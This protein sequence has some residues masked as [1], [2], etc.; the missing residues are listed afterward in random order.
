M[1]TTP[2]WTMSTT[3]DYAAHDADFT[4]MFRK[5]QSGVVVYPIMLVD[6]DTMQYKL[7]LTPDGAVQTF[8]PMNGLGSLWT[9]LKSV[10]H[11]L[12]WLGSLRQL[13]PIEGMDSVMARVSAKLQFFS[14]I[15]KDYDDWRTWLAKLPSTTMVGANY[16]DSVPL[17]FVTHDGDATIAAVQRIAATTT[18]AMDEWAGAGSVTNDDIARLAAVVSDDSSLLLYIINGIIMSCIYRQILNWKTQMTAEE[19]AGLNVV[20]FRGPVSVSGNNTNCR[21]RCPSTNAATRIFK[22]FMTEEQ[23]TQRLF[24]LVSR[25]ARTFE[26]A[27]PV[28]EAGVHSRNIADMMGNG[29]YVD[30]IKPALQNVSSGLTTFATDDSTATVIQ[31]CANAVDTPACP[32]SSGR[33]HNVDG[34]A[35]T[36][37]PYNSH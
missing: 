8:M 5:A 6:G 17:E 34:T 7:K 31:R 12:P 13:I 21:R 23:M 4:A 25:D 30:M 14:D 2:E 20:C 33:I 36:D 35:A 22:F 15:P 11:V 29:K 19:W 26:T 16:T 37:S 27:V 1:K 18:T 24:F 32:F 9:Y 3:V 10:S 28:V